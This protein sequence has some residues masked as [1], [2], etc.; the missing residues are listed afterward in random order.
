M[1]FPAPLVRGTRTPARFD[2][3]RL[4][5]RDAPVV[6]GQIGVSIAGGHRRGHASFTTT[7]VTSLKCTRPVFPVAFT[8]ASTMSCAG[9][10]DSA[11]PG[12]ARF[13]K[14]RPTRIGRPNDAVGE[15]TSTSPSL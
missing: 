1:V 4:T 7:T 9:S 15:S 8:S 13:A 10:L 5:T 12:E 11:A 6:F 14:P 3:K 2:A